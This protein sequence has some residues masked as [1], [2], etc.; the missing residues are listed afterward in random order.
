MEQKTM[1]PIHLEG[2]LPDPKPLSVAWVTSPEAQGELLIRLSGD[3]EVLID[4]GEG[5]SYVLRTADWTRLLVYLTPGYLCVAPY[6]LLL[7]GA[8]NLLVYLGMRIN[9]D[10]ILLAKRAWRAITPFA[11]YGQAGE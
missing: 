7:L 3:P 5:G 2:R 8:A 10:L 4:G 6:R 1:M 9:N 11:A